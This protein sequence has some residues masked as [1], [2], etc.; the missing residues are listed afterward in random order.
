MYPEQRD[1]LPATPVKLKI[2]I[3]YM[4]QIYGDALEQNKS[5]QQKGSPTEALFLFHIL[6]VKF[7]IWRM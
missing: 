1:L 3:Y 2:N 7:Y 4:T 6:R 5:V